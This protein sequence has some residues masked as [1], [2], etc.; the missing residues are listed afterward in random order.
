MQTQKKKK[1]S[2][3]TYIPRWDRKVSN[4]VAYMLPLSPST[5]TPL[6]LLYS[7]VFTKKDD[8]VIFSCSISH[9]CYQAPQSLPYMNT[10]C[11]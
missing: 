7:F 11:K 2:E 8:L 1:K 6:M 9:S 3:I 4:I 5:H 10:Q